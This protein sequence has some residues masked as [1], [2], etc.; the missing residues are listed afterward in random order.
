MLSGLAK[1]DASVFV[2]EGPE[3]LQHGD[4][5]FLVYSA[6]ACWTDYYELGMLTATSGSNLLDPK[7]WKKS[8]HPVFQQAPEAG[9]YDTG[10]NSLFKSPD[11]KEDW[12]LYH[13][14]SEPHQ[15]CGNHRSP[16]V[17]PFRWNPDGTPNF[18]KPL[19]VNEP[20]RR[21]SGK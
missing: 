10:H 19:P 14:N 9:V 16:R 3:I 5:L 7:S 4:R 1:L 20:I 21:P 13:A 12:I 17:Q 8:S 11:G 15:G 6:S 2:N 18:G